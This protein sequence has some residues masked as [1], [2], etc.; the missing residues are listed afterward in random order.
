MQC[1]G[2]PHPNKSWADCYQLIASQILKTGCGACTDVVRRGCLRIM[3][4]QLST[5]GREKKYSDL[6]LVW[7]TRVFL[8]IR[9]EPS[10]PQ[11]CPECLW[12]RRVYRLVC[13]AD[14]FPEDKVARM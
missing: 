13:T 4:D 12:V 1:S 8:R 9:Y 10:S 2:G 5:E 11:Q 3:S 6:L 7:K 14:G